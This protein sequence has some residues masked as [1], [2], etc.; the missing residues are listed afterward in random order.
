MWQNQKEAKLKSHRLQQQRK[1]YEMMKKFM[2]IKRP[3]EPC[4]VDVQASKQERRTKI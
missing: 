4:M 1:G 2:N 3:C